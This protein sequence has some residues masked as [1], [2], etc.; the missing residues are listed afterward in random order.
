MRKSVNA[1]LN[2]AAAITA[3]ALALST[4]GLYGL[5]IDLA[6]GG[7]NDPIDDGLSKGVLAV[8]VALVVALVVGSALH[9]SGPYV[10]KIKKRRV[11]TRNSRD[12]AK[13]RNEARRD[14]QHWK[15]VYWNRTH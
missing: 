5:T 1:A 14:R 9:L 6:N 12:A 2:T 10:A 15:M 4:G 7:L 8:A 11:A 13:R 3:S